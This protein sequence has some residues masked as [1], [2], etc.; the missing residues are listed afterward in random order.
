MVDPVEASD[1]RERHHTVQHRHE[2]FSRY[3]GVK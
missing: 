1:L 3:F 2:P